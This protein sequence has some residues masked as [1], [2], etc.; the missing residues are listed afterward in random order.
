MLNNEFETL[1]PPRQNKYTEPLLFVPGIY[2]LSQVGQIPY[3]SAVIPLQDLVNQINLVED[4]PE[5]SRLV[6]SLEELFQRDIDWKRVEDDLL[7]GYLKDQNKLSFFNSL[8]IA[9]LPRNGFKIEDSYGNAESSPLPTYESG[10][11]KQTNVGNICVESNSDGSIGLLRWHKEKIFPVAIDGQHRLAALKQYCTDLTLGVSPELNTKI[12]LI[13]LILD[14]RVGFKEN[15]ENSLI[16]TLRE[17]FI[18]LNRN[19]RGVPKSR[20]ILLDDLDIQYF[21]V[22]TL[23]A[24]HAKDPSPK[25]LPLSMVTWR[26][27]EAKFDSGY[28]LTTVLNLNDIVGSCLGGASLETIEA[29]EEDEIKKYVG[30]IKAKLELDSEIL[31]SVEEHIQLCVSRDDPFSFKTEHLSAIRE[32][33]RLQWAPHI[34]K[35]FREFAPYS[36]YLSTAKEIGAIDE[37]LADY[38]LLSKENREKFK[39]RKKAEDENFNPINEIDAPLS[40]LQKLKLDEWAFYV[41]FQKALFLNLFELEAQKQSLFAGLEAEIGE[42]REGFLSWWLAQINTLHKRGVF[43][44]NW[45]AEKEKADLWIGIAKNPVSGTIQYTKTAANKISAFMTICLWFNN[46]PKEQD[47]EAF[48]KSLIENTSTELPKI[49]QNAF[50]RTLRRGLESLVRSRTDTDEIDDKKLERKVKVELVKRLKATQE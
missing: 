45:K 6:W 37:T 44:L 46:R 10:G 34:I 17:I 47:A 7:N 28:S 20:I 19:A 14:D 16:K 25:T 33:F 31:N 32:T 39:N 27:D 12:P 1:S 15:R 26:E 35:V 41:V 36:E 23:L 9:L 50:Q 8:T 30:T 11:W 3:F 4:I 38:L 2:H 42:T 24:S 29:L 13:F 49:V 40:K 18:D 21:C 43:N 5:E 48:A 22:R